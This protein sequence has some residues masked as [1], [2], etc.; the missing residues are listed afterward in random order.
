MKTSILITLFVLIT[1]YCNS[2]NFKAPIEGE[3]GKDFIIVNYIDWGTN[4]ITDFRKGTKTY[5]GHRGTDFTLSGFP[6]MDEGVYVNAV[7]T[8]VVTF[9]HDGEYDR[10]TEGNTS[11]GL[12]NYIAIRHP[13]KLYSYYG[14]LKKNSLMV[15]TGDKVY[16]GQHIALVGSSGN[17]T[18]PHLHFELW[19][20]SLYLVEP[21]AASCGADNS[22]W[23]E[24][25]P[26]DT[27]FHVWE[28][29]LTDFIP[30]IN[31]LKNRPVEKVKFNEQDSIITFWALQYG[32]KEGDS[33]KIEW[34]TPNGS[35][36]FE[37]SYTYQK[38]WWYYYYNSY[39]FAP[40]SDIWG[41]WKYNYYYNDKLVL[42]GNFEIEKPSGI[43]ETKSSSYYRIIDN[44]TIEV[45]L[46][47]NIIPKTVKVYNISGQEILQKD[48]SHQN[49]FVLNISNSKNNPEV[50]LVSI[51]HKNGYWNFKIVL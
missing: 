37:Y 2:Q 48:I 51:K 20:D 26:Y 30:N 50:F 1:N 18:D 12:G 16:P 35:L 49:S 17:S 25:I 43:S 44:E 40:S 7:D 31:D 34:L 42:T 23:E 36:W 41:K 6:Q 24:S 19:Y 13:N 22:Y 46:P 45:F 47:Q 39:I 29:G 8:G 32:I 28:S 14:H 27:I 38:D 21:F 9:I 11:L 33:T 3:Y 4:Q 5:A 10:N 15:K